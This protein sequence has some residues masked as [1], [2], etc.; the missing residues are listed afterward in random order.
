VK[1]LLLIG[2]VVALFWNPLLPLKAI[3]IGSNIVSSI[4]SSAMGNRALGN[5]IQREHDRLNAEI[6]ALKAAEDRIRCERD[7]SVF[8]RKFPGVKG[9]CN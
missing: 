5:Y 1:T 6:S 2:I 8:E 7:I 3:Q 9:E 4:E